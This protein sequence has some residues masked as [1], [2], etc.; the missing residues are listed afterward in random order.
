VTSTARSTVVLVVEASGIHPVSYQWQRNSVNV[1][2]A[3]SPTLTLPN[4]M[5]SQAG[6]YTV[7][8]TDLIGTTSSATGMVTIGTPTPT[9]PDSRAPQT[10]NP[11]NIQELTLQVGA[12]LTNSA[13]IV[14]SPNPPPTFQWYHNTKP[15]FGETNDTLV[16]TN[17]QPWVSSVAF[18]SNRHDW[19]AG[20]YSVAATNLFGGVTSSWCI[21]LAGELSLDTAPALID[22]QPAIRIIAT[23]SPGFV[24]QGTPDLN[25]PTVWTNLAL[26]CGATCFE[27]YLPMRGW[28]FRHF[29]AA[30][31][32][33]P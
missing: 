5:P 31:T 8:V 6:A 10:G 19:T 13:N 3:T 22:G 30:P 21:K 28:E 15:L 24:L 12:N 11:T 33:C 23:G 17:L 32:N 4:L 27:Y 9:M 26:K 16:L 7:R 25:P 20:H 29:R 1:A 2:G 14:N 18:S